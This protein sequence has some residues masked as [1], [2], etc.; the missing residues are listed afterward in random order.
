MR[1][2]ELEMID[3]VVIQMRI[4][5]KVALHPNLNGVD[6]INCRKMNVVKD[7]I[8]QK[9]VKLI[10]IDVVK[11]PR[12]REDV[13][14]ARLRNVIR[15]KSVKLIEIDVVKGLQNREDVIHQK[16]VKLIGINVVKDL[17][18]NEDVVQVH[19]QSATL[20]NPE[21]RS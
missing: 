8:R 14:K 15:Q 1:K 4:D 13:V 20:S 16:S 2:I 18:N 7:G 6:M 3:V 10:E 17:Q 9:S 5:V 19:L 21:L 11:G 12:N